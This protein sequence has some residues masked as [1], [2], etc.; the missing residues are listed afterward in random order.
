VS[1]TEE[2]VAAEVGVE[3]VEV[4]EGDA[5]GIITIEFAICW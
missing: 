5:D 1:E 3:F 2:A 4:G